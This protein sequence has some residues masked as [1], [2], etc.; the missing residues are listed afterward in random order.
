MSFLVRILTSLLFEIGE[1]NGV[2]KAGEIQ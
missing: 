1:G 2:G